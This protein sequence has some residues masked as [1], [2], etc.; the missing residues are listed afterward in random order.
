MVYGY[1][2]KKRGERNDLTIGGLEKM[3]TKLWKTLEGGDILF[4]CCKQGKSGV[5]VLTSFICL[6]DF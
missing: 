6:L 1:R 4:I 3:L 2:E 5:W